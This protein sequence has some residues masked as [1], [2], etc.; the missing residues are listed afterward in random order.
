MNKG[1]AERIL[2][3]NWG[4]R[5][6]QK[7]WLLHMNS[8]RHIHLLFLVA[9]L[10]GAG[11][12]RSDDFHVENL[13]TQFAT[14]NSYA[15]AVNASGTVAGYF[16]DTNGLFRAYA[17]EQNGW[18]LIGSPSTDY[19]ALALN[20]SNHIVGYRE[21]GGLGTAFHAW[22]TNFA[23]LGTFDG[24]E[25]FAL[26]INDKTNIVGHF[27]TTNGTSAFVITN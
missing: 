6:G 3:L 10:I 7:G 1:K 16:K 27:R 15:L 20:G 17:L 4:K 25:S 23:S 12:G 8:S 11:K 9:F 14:T 18:T 13:G 26:G 5:A 24:T 22:G 19:F 2:I 21:A